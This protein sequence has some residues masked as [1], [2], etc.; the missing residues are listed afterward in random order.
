MKPVSP[1]FE[2]P[3]F[4]ERI[5]IDYKCFVDRSKDSEQLVLQ[6]DRRIFSRIFRI[7]TFVAIIVFPLFFLFLVFNCLFAGFVFLVSDLLVFIY[8]AHK[9]IHFKNDILIWIMGKDEILKI[10]PEKEERVS[11]SPETFKTLS[12]FR[13]DF[14]LVKLLKFKRYSLALIE[15]DLEYIKLYNGRKEQCKKLGSIL[16]DVVELEPDNQ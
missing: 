3:E 13:D 15:N 16:A 5:H 14:M 7:L 4:E 8:F 9:Y 2:I 12:C 11:F 6:V 1:D 10:N